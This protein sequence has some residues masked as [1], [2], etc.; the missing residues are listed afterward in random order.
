MEWSNGNTTVTEL[1]TDRRVLAKML[2]FMDLAW[3]FGGTASILTQ[4]DAHDWHRSDECLLQLHPDVCAPHI[5]TG[6]TAN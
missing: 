1:L 4:Q 5:W 6:V 2:H 3:A